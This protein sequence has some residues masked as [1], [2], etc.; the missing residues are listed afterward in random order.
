[1]GYTYLGCYADNRNRVMSRFALF[2]HSEMTREVCYD[3][4]DNI[5]SKRIFDVV[6]PGYCKS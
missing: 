5:Y 6:C 4:E 1:M 3:G 2:D